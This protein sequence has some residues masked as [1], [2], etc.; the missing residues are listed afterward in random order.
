MQ[1]NTHTHTCTKQVREAHS[2][3]IGEDGGRSHPAPAPLVPFPACPSP[4]PPGL[5][6]T[7]SAYKYNGAYSTGLSVRVLEM[8]ETL[9]SSAQL[10]A[11]EYLVFVGMAVVLGYA[12][13]WYLWVH[14]ALGKAM[15]ERGKGRP[16]VLTFIVAVVCCFVIYWTDEHTPEG[17]DT[18]ILIDNCFNGGDVVELQAGVPGTKRLGRVQAF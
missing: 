11:W 14:Q 8:R 1:G 2:R 18:Q 15:R 4:S 10:Q 3:R 7:H 6:L 16:L 5:S 9:E 13:S 17:L 12:S